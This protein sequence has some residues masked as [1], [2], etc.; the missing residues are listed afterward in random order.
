MKPYHKGHHGLVVLASETCDKVFLAVSL[1]DRK[2]PGELEIRGEVMREVW[3]QCIIPIIP[4]N[5]SLQF[6]EQSPIKDIY[7]QLA[8][9]DRSGLNEEHLIFCGEDDQDRFTPK[10]LSAFA[11]RLVQEQRISLKP[12]TRGGISGTKMRSFLQRGEKT[13]FF[14]NLPKE[15]VPCAELV[16]GSLTRDI[17]D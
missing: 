7:V 5:V 10:K 4:H 17:R 8:F 6:S 13:L 11:P 9:A 12:M 1:K 3:K 15:M 2:R 14:E 16:W